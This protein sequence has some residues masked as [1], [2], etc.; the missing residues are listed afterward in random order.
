MNDSILVLLLHMIQKG[1]AA[2]TPTT[3]DRGKGLRD[4]AVHTLQAPCT[5]PSGVLTSSAVHE[6]TL[7]AHLGIFWR[8]Q[9]LYGKGQFYVML[10]HMLHTSLPADATIILHT[11]YSMLQ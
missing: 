9:A 3:L 1:C 11:V 6:L 8:A 4:E 2:K 5:S 10:E 7:H